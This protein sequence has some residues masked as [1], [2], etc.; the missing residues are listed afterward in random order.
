MKL[1]HEFVKFRYKVLYEIKEG[2][3]VFFVNKIVL[4]FATD[5]QHMHNR[6]VR[7]R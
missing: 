6:S 5:Q 2:Q 7:N 1:K 3:S 4:L